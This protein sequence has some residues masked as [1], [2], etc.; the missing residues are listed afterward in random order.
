MAHLHQLGV[1][2]HVA[3]VAAAVEL[4]GV[5][6]H[7]VQVGHVAFVVDH[8]LRPLAARAP[9]LVCDSD[10]DDNDGDESRGK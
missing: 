2:R 9:V 4:D 1:E 3:L 6:P 8:L 5:E 10:R 7:G